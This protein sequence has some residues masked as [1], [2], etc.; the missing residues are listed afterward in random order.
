MS[1]WAN[2]SHGIGQIV[3]TTARSAQWAPAPGGGPELPPRSG[4]GQLHGTGHHC[5]PE[6]RGEVYRGARAHRQRYRPLALLPH[7]EGT[8]PSPL[9]PSPLSLLPHVEYLGMGAVSALGN[10]GLLAYSA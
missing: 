9:F 7:V 3:H 5:H 4:G 6:V 2:Q 8:V 10:S 1:V